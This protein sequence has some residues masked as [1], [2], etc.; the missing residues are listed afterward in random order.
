MP[1]QYVKTAAEEARIPQEEA[2]AAWAKAKEITKAEYD[3][4][5]SDETKFYSIV[6][7]IFKNILRLTEQ[8]MSSDIAVDNPKPLK[9]M[10]DGLPCFECDD[11]TFW[12]LHRNVRKDKQ[13]WDKF[14]GNEI[15]EW[16][17]ANK[18]KP[19]YVQHEKMGLLRK[20]KSK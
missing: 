12:H 4:D 6:T 10:P 1:V 2:E 19:F 15:A 9:K 14:Y 16:G 20:I 5:A 13:W 11:D 8:V 3:V 17:K 18:G 7:G